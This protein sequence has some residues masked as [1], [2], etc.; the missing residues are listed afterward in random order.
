MDCLIIYFASRQTWSIILNFLGFS[1]L[2]PWFF[3]IQVRI[4]VNATSCEELPKDQDREVTAHKNYFV[5]LKK[6]ALTYV[7]VLFSPMCTRFNQDE[8]LGKIFSQTMDCCLYSTKKLWINPLNKL[9]YIL[10]TCTYTCSNKHTCIHD[11]RF[12]CHMCISRFKYKSSQS[13]N[14]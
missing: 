10:C 7:F 12:K 14:L 6:E 1:E 13:P 2:R 9:I 11:L 5:F 8:D 3:L 4:W